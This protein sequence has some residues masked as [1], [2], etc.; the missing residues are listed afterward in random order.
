MSSTISLV[1]FTSS[2]SGE[3]R[4]LL[5]TAAISCGPMEFWRKTVVTLS[6]VKG[7]GTIT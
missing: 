6:M 1:T 2:L 4:D 5:D 7:L 3:R